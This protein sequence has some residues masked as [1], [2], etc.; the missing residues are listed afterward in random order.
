MAQNLEKLHVSFCGVELNSPIAMGAIGEHWGTVESDPVE[1]AKINAGILEKHAEAGAGF[2]LLN[3]IFLD[4]ETEKIV[5]E[6]TEFF[7]TSY[8]G[9]PPSNGRMIPITGKPPYGSEGFYYFPS[10]FWPGIEHAHH[11]YQKNIEMMKHLKKHLP[12]DTKVMANVL[13]IANV[14]ESYAYSAKCWQDLG[15]DFLEVNVSCPLPSGHRDP[16]GKYVRNLFPPFF[17]GFLVGDQLENVVAIT[18]AVAEAVD[19]PFGIKLSPETGFPRIVLFAKAC[20]ENGADFVTMF[21]AGVGLAPPDIW[22]DGKPTLDF[23]DGSPFCMASGSFLRVNS[24]RD[25]GAVR[26]FVRDLGI[27]CSGGLVEPEHM[28][29]AMMLGAETVQPCTG[30]I[31]QG[32]G[33]IRRTVKEMNKL[34]EEKGYDSIQDIIGMGQ[35]YIM[36]NEDVYQ[37]NGHTKVVIDQEKC[38]RCQRCTDNICQS[39]HFDKEKKCV[40]LYYDRCEGCGGCLLACPSGAL[41]LTLVD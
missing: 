11:T 38:T 3:G 31:E 8:P 23:C 34:V 39:I 20:K 16:V 28:I 15:A 9:N 13:G 27:S 26:R 41:S 36:N 1:F 29:Q 12:Q 10:P 17:Q 30:V 40:E 2:V 6:S 25:T 35:K 37:H 32:R 21:N 33:L 24:L 22:N 5:E 7:E 19:I 18:R 4:E 14:P